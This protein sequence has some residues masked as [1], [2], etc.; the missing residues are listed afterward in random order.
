MKNIPC[1]LVLFMLLGVQVHAQKK[2]KYLAENDPLANLW[3]FTG[4]PKSSVPLI[5]GIA[6][7][8]IFLIPEG[9]QQSMIAVFEV[10]GNFACPSYCVASSDQSNLY[11]E[12]GESCMLELSDEAKFL[13]LGY[14]LIKGGKQVELTLD[15]E[16]YTYKLWGE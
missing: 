7:Q 14:K 9:S 13:T 10:E 3:E 1:L 11:L 5:N 6:H 2:G 12:I 4:D 16:K 8:F 15:G